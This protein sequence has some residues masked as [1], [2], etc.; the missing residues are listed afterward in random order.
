[1]EIWGQ[2]GTGTEGHR[3]GRVLTEA[4]GRCIRERVSDAE[5]MKCQ[6]NLKSTTWVYLFR[7][8]TVNLH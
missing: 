3:R 5:N 7:K 6:K 1:M 4:K 8:G 2:D